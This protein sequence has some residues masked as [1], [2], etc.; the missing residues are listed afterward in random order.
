MSKFNRTVKPFPNKWQRRL[1]RV[2]LRY[3][4]G[5]CD[6][7]T[8]EGKVAVCDPGYEDYTGDLKLFYKPNIYKWLGKYNEVC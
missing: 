5:R 4:H 2:F 6:R 1:L 7:W 8:I 3:M